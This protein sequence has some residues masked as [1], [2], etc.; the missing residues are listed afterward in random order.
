MNFIGRETE[1]NTLNDLYS[2][3][4]CKGAI[5]YGRRRFGKTSLLIESSHNFNGK[6]IYYQCLDTSDQE[7]AKQLFSAVE[8]VFPNA[9][10]FGNYS[11]SDVLS[12]IFSLAKAQPI[13]LILD[14]YPYLHDRNSIDSKFQDLIDHNLEINLKLILSGSYVNI[15]E[16]LLD[17]NHPLH[18]RFMYKIMLEPFDYYDSSMFYKNASEVDKVRFYS[19]FGGVP[20]YLSMIDSNSSFEDNV[21]KLLLSTYAPLQLGIE[22]TLRQEYSK[23]NNASFVMSLI[24]RGKHSYTDINQAFKAQVP[25]SDLNYILKK[26]LDMKFIAKTYAINDS[27]KSSAYYEIED[28]LYAFFYQVIYPTLGKK[29]LFDVNTYFERFVKDKMNN[30]FIPHRFEKVCKEFLIRQNRKGAMNPLFES[31]GSYTYNNP[32]K[33]KNG[34]FDLVTIDENGNTFYECKFTNEKVG[35]S[36]IEEEIKQ[37]KDAGVSYYRLGFFSKAGYSLKEAG[38]DNLYFSLKD[39]FIE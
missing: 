10:I 16:H 8:E 32:K 37:L 25:D 17:D 36:V 2:Q 34:Q 15:M 5:L 18:G 3:K 13:L 39:L 22:T 31:I 28:N 12:L 26:L 19:V 35:S 11:F 30:D 14:E 27:K 20:Y 1:L 29:P 4:G 7:N 33:H 6:V 23:I 9:S 24:I 21:K 38:K